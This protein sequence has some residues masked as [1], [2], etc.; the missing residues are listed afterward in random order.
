MSNGQDNIVAH[1]WPSG[2]SGNPSGKPKGT[3]SLSTIIK[4]LGDSPPDWDK[5]S[6][7][8]IDKFK[9]RFH[10]NSAWEAVIY[11]AFT[12]AMTGDD[13]ARRWL[14]ESAFGKN[15]NLNVDETL[16]VVHIFKPAK[17]E[18]IED[19]NKMGQELR[20]KAAKA[21]EGEVVD[22]V[23]SPTRP[24]DVRTLPA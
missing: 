8:D 5:L 22:G 21:V 7:R 19:L 15:I 20:D 6:I 12:Q 4:K 1:Q 2:V 14:S 16:E 18:S 24:A 11:V 3:K 23:D 9:R 10:N 13:K 17:V